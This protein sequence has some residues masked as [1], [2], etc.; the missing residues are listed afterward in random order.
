M[1]NIFNSN[2]GFFDF[3]IFIQILHKKCNK[4][5]HNSEDKTVTDIK[6]GPT[7]E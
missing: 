4:T 6:P 2:D 1:D 7:R 5:C 3:Q